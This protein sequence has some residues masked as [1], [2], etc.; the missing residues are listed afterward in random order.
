MRLL[1]GLAILMLS[2]PASAA[3]SNPIETTQKS[4]ESQ[5]RKLI[6]PVLEKYC[7]DECKLMSVSTSVDVAVP[8]SVAPGFDEID[9]RPAS[10][11]APTSGKAK[12]LINEKIGPVSRRKLLDLVQQYLD[13]LDFPVKVETQL[14]RFP[15]PIESTGKIAEMRERIGRQFKD[16]LNDLFKQFCPNQC[17]LADFNL[18][19]DVVNGE[20]AQYGAAGEYVVSGGDGGIALRIRDLSATI[21]VDD[22]LTPEEQANILEMA[23]LKTNS[24]KNVNLASKAMKFPRPVGTEAELNADGTLRWAG[25]RGTRNSTSTT[26]KKDS[27][28][29]ST[30]SN[31]N[32]SQTKDS[33]SLTDTRNNTTQSAD[34]NNRQEKFERFEKIERVE[35]GDAIQKELDKF[36]VYGLVFACAILSMLVFLAVAAFRKNQELVSGPS[37]KGTSD[38]ADAQGAPTSSEGASPSKDRIAKNYEIERLQEELTDL[39]ALQPKV[40]KQVFTRVLTEEGVETTAEYIHIFGEGVVVDMLRDPSLQGDLGE[41]MEYY[42]KNPV[43]LTPDE[44]LDLLKRLHNRAVAGKLIVIGNRSSNLFDF[45]VEMDA[46][47]ILELIRTESITVKAIVVTQCDSQKRAAIFSQLEEDAR[48]SLLTELSRIDY[49]PRDFIFNV[50]NAL[51]RKRR[52]NPKLNTE[53]LPGSEVLVNLLER[54]PSHLQK[55][56]IRSLEASS[57]ESVRSIKSKL[58]CIDALRFLR[59]SQLLEVILSLKH[60]E[61]LLFLK[62]T[63]AEIKRAVLT[64]CPKDLTSELEEELVNCPVPHRDAYQN[65]ERKLVHRM[66]HMAT[67]GVINL[68]ETNERMLGAQSESGGEEEP[69]IR[70]ASGW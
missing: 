18:A 26:E 65:L 36:K 52:E 19:T 68:I 31:T 11:L 10:E 25:G 48:M 23:R 63:A 51:K 38:A 15:E 17:L 20:E 4:A 46:V 41:L 6:E 28:N 3:K 14:A 1:L 5:I 24:F 27:A 70:K 40:A 9:T 34:T 61:L 39:F 57:P 35:Q 8:D 16:T 64:R 37:H 44:K 47:Q 67:E 59:D 21:L 55:A 50:S 33:K 62:G 2:F 53:A 32:D 69:K 66:K 58:I 7:N 22:S 30:N 13:T 42:A 60:D 54:T 12:I 29:S 45:L 56:V 43:E 49:L